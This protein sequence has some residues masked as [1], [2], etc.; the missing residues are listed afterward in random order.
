MTEEK[1]ATLAETIAEAFE[2]QEAPAEEPTE[3]PEVEAAPV[4]DSADDAA[5]AA[6]DGDQ[7][8]DA[9]V[10][11]EPI[12]EPEEVVEA[13]PE[14]EPIDYPSSWNA[15]TREKVE[16]LP[17]DLQEYFVSREK[18]QNATFTQKTQELS[19]AR[20]YYENL[21]RAIQPYAQ[22]FALQGMQ[23]EQV[24]SRLLAT[25]DLLDKDPQAGLKWIADSYGVD[26]SQL[27]QQAP[28]NTDPALQN[29][30]NE[31]RELKGLIQNWQ[32]EQQQKMQD[33]LTAEAN[34]FI[35]EVD[36]DGNRA[37]PYVEDVSQEM[38][39]LVSHLR[40]ANPSWSNKE[41]LKQ[42]YEKACRLN[43]GVWAN[44][45]KRNAAAEA[46]KQQV[47]KAAK[48]AQAK[49]A[50]SSVTGAPSG[51]TSKVVPESLRAQIEQA[52]S[53]TT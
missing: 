44:L 9:T 39:P 27:P 18:E 34:A 16:A 32:Q 31:V 24:I 53:E 5:E 33:A 10:V 6:D 1:E 46:K 50:A 23:P 21:D 36:S 12:S 3:T 8:E 2:E 28:E 45:Q 52:Y 29:V 15:E 17:R 25:Q 22:H 30:N 4:D 42:A 43:D 48:I 13:E 41:V 49:K 7:S 40:E 47:S 38:M 37:H 11:E 19:K 35:H 51:G 26:L 20:Q 14:L